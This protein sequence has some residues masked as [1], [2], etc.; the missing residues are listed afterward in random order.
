MGFIESD[1]VSLAWRY[2][3][4]SAGDQSKADGHLGGKTD[5]CDSYVGGDESG[6]CGMY[7]ARV[8]REKGAKEDQNLAGCMCR[9]MKESGTSHIESILKRRLAFWFL[10]I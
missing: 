7:I 2:C 10:L 8:G 5:D 6:D 1:V 9:R 4:I 3:G